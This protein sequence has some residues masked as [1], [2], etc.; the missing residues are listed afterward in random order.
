MWKCDNCG[1]VFDDTEIVTKTTWSYSNYIGHGGG[2]PETESFCPNCGSA[3]IYEATKCDLCGGYDFGDDFVY[4]D[5]FTICE[6]CA[7]KLHGIAKA[8]IEDAVG[9]FGEIDSVQAQDL[10]I[11][12]LQE[13]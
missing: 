2:F 4:Y 1:E 11:A 5:N 7:D 13:Y 6:E 12:Y 10:L 8:L 3:E 9:E